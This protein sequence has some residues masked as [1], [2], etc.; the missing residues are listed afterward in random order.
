MLLSGCVDD[1]ARPASEPPDQTATETVTETPTP[2]AETPTY[3]CDAAN[4]P[5]SPEPDADPPGDAERYTYP[6]RPDSLSNE[7]IR[8]F[9]ERYER[10]YR[11]NKLHSE[12]GANLNRASLSVEDTDTYD[13]PDGAAIA[14]V[15]HTYDA[16]ID[17]DDG[18]IEID[19]PIIYA[20][21]YVDDDVVLR[22]VNKRL[23]EDVSRLVANPMET[24]QPVECFSETFTRA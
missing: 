7:E 18:P 21:Y 11:L 14:Q 24:G 8:S 10:A 12:W 9:A 6:T 4:R 22:S 2:G 1:T 3:D 20:S 15:K 13:A 5:A 17:G 16:E 19:S 23:Q